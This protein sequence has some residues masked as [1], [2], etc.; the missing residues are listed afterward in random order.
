LRAR[1]TLVNISS[2]I[3]QVLGFIRLGRTPKARNGTDIT[4][5]SGTGMRICS[6][7]PIQNFA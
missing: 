1:I 2:Q 3:V 7:H 6:Q 4:P 5:R